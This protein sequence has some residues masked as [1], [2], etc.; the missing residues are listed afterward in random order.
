M[1]LELEMTPTRSPL[2]RARARA[3]SAFGIDDVEDSHGSVVGLAPRRHRPRRR[4]LGEPQFLEDEPH[5]RG[6][7][8]ATLGGPTGMGQHAVVEAH[9]RPPLGMLHSLGVTARPRRASCPAMAAWVHPDEG[10]AG[11]E[12]KGAQAIA[13]H[14][15]AMGPRISRDA[16]R[17]M[18]RR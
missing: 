1:P 12:E 6:A 13:T 11:I 10:V 8:V 9:P 16:S 3:A 5:I 2:A 15:S 18:H 17:I 4:R 14:A 7:R